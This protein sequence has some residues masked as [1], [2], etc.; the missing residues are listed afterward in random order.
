MSGAIAEVRAHIASALSG[1]GVPVHTYPPGSVQP[2]CVLL[3][4]GS[5]YLQPG[6]AWGSVNVGVNVRVV[7]NDA[8]GPDGVASLDELLEAVLDAL[9]AAEGVNVDS[10]SEPFA[11][12]EQGVQI[13]DIPTITNRRET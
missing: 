10:V 1:V 8:Y 7:A 2:P 11:D 9:V 12:T 13:F 4:P 5:P 6:A 3:M